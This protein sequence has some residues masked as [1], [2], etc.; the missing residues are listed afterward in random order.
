MTQAFLDTDVLLDFLAGRSPFSEE[1][2][3]IFEHAE[4]KTLRLSISSTSVTNLYYLLK[5]HNTHQ[6]VIHALEELSGLVKILPVNE[7]IIG[8]ALKSKFRDFEDAVQFFTA[9]SSKKN[10]FLVTRNIKDYK[11]ATLPVLSPA[12]FMKTIQFHEGT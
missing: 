8:K 11:W 2:A 5:R 3:W 4:N 1:A 7:S 9:I 10:Q 6:S 12:T